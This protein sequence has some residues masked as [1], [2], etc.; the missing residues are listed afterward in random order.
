[1]VIF[2]FLFSYYIELSL[3]YFRNFQDR[4]TNRNT[5]VTKQFSLKHHRSIYLWLPNGRYLV[6]RLKSNDYSV[7]NCWE[8]SCTEYWVVCN[9]GGG[10]T[11][12]LRYINTCAR[13]NHSIHRPF[14]RVYIKMFLLIIII[15]FIFSGMYSE[16]WL[17]Q[18]KS[19]QS[20]QE[21]LLL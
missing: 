18:S 5:W 8:H 3:A 9:K 11:M 20:H 15:I 16:C 7:N 12:I 13:I 1:M 21:K 17:W 4:T 10:V 6:N 2:R 19:W 14:G